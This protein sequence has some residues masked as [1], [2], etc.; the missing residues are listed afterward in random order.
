MEKVQLALNEQIAGDARQVSDMTNKAREMDNKNSEL[1]KRIAQLVR[2]KAALQHRVDELEAVREERLTRRD[3]GDARIRHFYGSGE[4]HTPHYD[5]ERIRTE[6]PRDAR[7][8]SRR[9]NPTY[10]GRFG[11]SR[12]P[13]TGPR[14]ERR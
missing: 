5:N 9:S 6:V 8:R 10:D 12:Q 7:S 14:A 11:A 4:S 2:E 13:P 3:A 1:Q